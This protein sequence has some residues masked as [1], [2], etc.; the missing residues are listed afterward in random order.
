MI[1]AERSVPRNPT[2]KILARLDFRDLISSVSLAY[3]I[4]GRIWLLMDFLQIILHNCM[5]NYVG[6][7]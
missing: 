7:D 5:Y 3:L 6:V 4:R 2:N 1:L